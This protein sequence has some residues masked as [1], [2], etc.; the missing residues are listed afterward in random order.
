MSS[1]SLKRVKQIRKRSNNSFLDGIPIGTDGL[2]VDMI[3]GLD[4]E[5]QLKLGG[6]HYVDIKQ[7]DTQTEIREWYL[8]ES[9]GN[10]PIEQIEDSKVKFT[11]LTAIT[12]SIQYNII[13]QEYEEEESRLVDN[14]IVVNKENISFDDEDPSTFDFL[15]TRE[16]AISYVTTINVSLYIGNFQTEIH[17][18]TIYI[19]ESTNGEIAV[20]EQVDNINSVYPWDDRNETPQNPEPEPEPIEPDDQPDN[21]QNGNGNQNQTG[22]QSGSQNGNENQLNNQTGNQGENNGNENENEN[23]EVEP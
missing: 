17:H 14:P 20:D 23:G 21:N 13:Q 4:L 16:Q 1:S 3:S 8:T 2:L 12:N 6:N 22:N 5:E 9:K 7:T 11:C 18:K 19:Y 15:V 10:T